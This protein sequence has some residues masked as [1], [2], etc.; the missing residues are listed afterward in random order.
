[1]IAAGY[2]GLRV[3]K[4]YWDAAQYEDT[5]KQHARFAETFNDRQIHD[6]IIAK[7]DSLGLPEEAKDVTVARVGRHI[8]ISA[9]YTVLVELPLHVRP[10]RFTPHIEYDY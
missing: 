10:F 1:M 7:A 5:M 6:R 4:V 9:D 8:T 3:G 2:F